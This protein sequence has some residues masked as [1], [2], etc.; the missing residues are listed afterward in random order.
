[1]RILKASQ[2]EFT[3]NI[4]SKIMHIISLLHYESDIKLRYNCVYHYL[5]NAVIKGINRYVFPVKAIAR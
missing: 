1:M 4:Y 2:T 5:I 3:I